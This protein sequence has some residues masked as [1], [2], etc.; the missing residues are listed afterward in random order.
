MQFVEAFKTLGYEV[1]SPRQDWSTEKPDGV[2]ISLWTKEIVW[3]PTPP[4]FDLWSLYEPGQNEWESLPGH[5]KRTRHLQRA[6]SE[7]GG[8]VDVVIVTGTPGEN[9]GTTDPWLPDQRKNHAWR[10]TKFD[11]AT[12]FFSA[13]CKELK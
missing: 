8:K 6:V 12:G 7:F 4:S 9:Y 5:S 1:P 2:C 10:V 13:A 3:A 11:K